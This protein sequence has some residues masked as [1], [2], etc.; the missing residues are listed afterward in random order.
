VIIPVRTARASIVLNGVDYFSKLAPYFLSMS[1]TDNC[2][3]KK[4]DDLEIKLADRDRRFIN[5]WMPDKGTFLDAAI[6]AERWFAPNASGLKLDCGRFWID[7]VEFSLPDHTVSI[8][9]SSIP[10]DANI[11]GNDE[12][13]G[14][15]KTTLQDVANQIAGE[16]QM[17]VQWEAQHNPRYTR[18]EQVEESGLAFLKKRA[19]DAKLAIKVCRSKIIFFDELTYESKA[20]ATTIVYGDMVGGAGLNCYRMSGGHFVT[21]LTDKTKKATVTH[22]SLT[23]GKMSKGF[24]E[25]SDPEL[26]GGNGEFSNWVQNVA[27]GTDDADEDNE[28]DDENGDGSRAVGDP[29]LVDDYTSTTGNNLKAQSVVRNKNKDKEN[30]KIALSIGNPLIAA[31]TTFVLKG[32]GQYDGN[33]FIVSAHHTVGPQY[34]T[35]LEVRRCLKGI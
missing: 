11:K 35:E 32:V 34:D 2:D 22:T 8:K 12:T 31:G 20:P 29:N 25:S 10:T 16:N 4:A 15:E 6:I 24:A 1:Y 18:I 28:D 27:E 21:Q 26:V 19:E 13:R 14:W 23:T 9:A 3:G 7:S 5:D 33:Y 17:S 30:A